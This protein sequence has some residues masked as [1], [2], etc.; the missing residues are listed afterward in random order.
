MLCHEK[1][2]IANLPRCV[3][4]AARDA[5]PR[6]GQ[7]PGGSIPKRYSHNIDYCT[8]QRSTVCTISTCVVQDREVRI[9][10]RRHGLASPL[11]TR[12]GGRCASP[13]GHVPHVPMLLYIPMH[14]PCGRVRKTPSAHCLHT[15]TCAAQCRCSTSF[16]CACGLAHGSWGAWHPSQCAAYSITSAAAIVASTA[17][18]RVRSRDAARSR[19]SS[20]RSLNPPL[21]HTSCSLKPLALRDA[22]TRSAAG[23]SAA[24]P[25]NRANCV[26]LNAWTPNARRR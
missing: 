11:D 10:R 6:Y 24:R 18:M 3:L 4:A 2:P 13:R 25:P 20:S 14:R 1:E 7:A 19:R 16:L 15:C 26:D 23:C 22:H 9:H 21:S 8:L 5:K 12:D 17:S